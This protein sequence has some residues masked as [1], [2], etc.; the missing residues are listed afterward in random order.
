GGETP[1]R[2]SRLRVAGSPP[3]P[4]WT[5]Q[6]PEAAAKIVA[7][8]AALGHELVLKPLFG[9]QGRGL[10]RLSDPALLPAPETVAGIY[11]LQ[12]F[13]APAESTYRDCRVLVS[14]GRA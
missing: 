5:V 9:A 14:A 10:L 2:R 3:P 11:Y 8:E 6:S 12:R 7:A 4:A 13:I 1:Q